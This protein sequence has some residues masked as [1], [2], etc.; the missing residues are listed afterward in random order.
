M[1]ISSRALK[2]T[3]MTKLKIASPTTSTGPPKAK[4]RIMSKTVVLWD[5][6]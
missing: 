4:P 2:I 5:K 1:T 3:F 6:H